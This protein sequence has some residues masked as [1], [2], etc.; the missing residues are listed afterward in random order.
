MSDD[1]DLF[2]L[3]KGRDLRD[4]GMSSVAAAE[5]D[6]AYEFHLAVLSLPSG[7]T[8]QCEDIRRGWKGTIP[9]PNAWGA[10][11]SAAVRRGL[12]VELPAKVSMTGTKSHGRRTHLYRRA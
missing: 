12:L 11:W 9:H 2:N 1:D 6:F 3:L 7:W 5:P 8:G 4:A 10:A